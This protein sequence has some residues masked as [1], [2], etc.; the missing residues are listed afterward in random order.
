[1]RTEFAYCP[2]V[3]M[4]FFSPSK[5]KKTCMFKKSGDSKLR[6]WTMCLRVLWGTGELSGLYYFISQGTPLLWSSFIAPLGN[7]FCACIGGSARWSSNIRG[8]PCPNQ[9]IFL[10]L[11]SRIHQRKL[12]LHHYGSLLGVC[13]PSL[14]HEAQRQ[15]LF[16]LYLLPV[17]LWE[18]NREVLF[19]FVLLYKFIY[20]HTLPQKLPSDC[21]LTC[22]K[23]C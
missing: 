20:K 18:L 7:Q 10:C 19:L 14:H 2:H 12:C 6:E 23:A 5:V 16:A 11:C 9:S 3:C 4:E 21:S 15:T 8:K 17:A 1:M 22:F 13:V